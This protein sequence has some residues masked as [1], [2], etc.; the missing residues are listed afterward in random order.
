[1]AYVLPGPTAERLK[2]RWVIRDDDLNLLSSILS[3][4]KSTG[5]VAALKFIFGGISMAPAMLAAIVA[6]VFVF[7][8]KARKK[9]VTLTDLQF[10]IVRALKS[11]K[12][13]MS[14]DQIGK[15][16]SW[17]KR[18]TSR[19]MIEATLNELTKVRLKDGTVVPLVTQDAHGLWS[20][21]GI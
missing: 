3:G 13:G 11:S 21:T 7:I 5:G 15:W 18:K 19:R 9:G 4:A 10:Q 12:T 14:V 20:A 16:L 2:F 1:M 8:Y 6:T 17:A